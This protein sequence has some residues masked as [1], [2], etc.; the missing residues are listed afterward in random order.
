[1][2]NSI[3]HHS[4]WAYLMDQKQEVKWPEFCFRSCDLE[5]RKHG[6]PLNNKDKC[7]VMFLHCLLGNRNVDYLRL[8]IPTVLVIYFQPILLTLRCPTA[9]VICFPVVILTL[10]N[11]TFCPQGAFMS[12]ICFVEQ[13]AMI[14]AYSIVT[15]KERLY[16]A[17]Q[18]E[19]L[20]IT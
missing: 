2:Y 16:C 20:H 9:H 14:S 19:P 10:H 12:L 13:T 7:Q 3:T 11:S 8:K 5:N 18:A 6:Y 4:P 15:E 1:M 17:V